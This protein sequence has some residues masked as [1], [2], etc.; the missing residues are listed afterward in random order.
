MSTLTLTT[1]IITAIVGAASCQ[2]ARVKDEAEDVKDAREDVQDAHEDVSDAKEELREESHELEKERIEFE[3]DLQRR[4]A[5]AEKRYAELG[6][7]ADKIKAGHAD[8]TIATVIDAAK[9]RAN[10]E[11]ETLRMATPATVE[12]DLERL[13]DALDYYDDT[14]DKH[15]D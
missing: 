11:I 3:A 5:T 6:L 13:D 14:L 7:R 8:T 2:N 15:E 4:L 10:A 1:I 12:Q 9:Q